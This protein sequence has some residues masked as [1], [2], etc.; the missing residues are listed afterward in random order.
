MIGELGDEHMGEQPGTREPP[1]RLT[2]RQEGADRTLTAL[3]V[4]VEELI[5]E[6]QARTRRRGPAPKLQ[7][8]L[9]RISQLP[10][11]KQRFVMEVLESVLAQA[12]R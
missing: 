2:R 5:G 6:P 7:Q 10:R 11:A 12:S 9:E 1:R 4:S 8:H 3:G